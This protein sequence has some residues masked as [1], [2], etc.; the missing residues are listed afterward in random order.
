MNQEY[1][2]HAELATA[3]FMALMNLTDF[4]GQIR[5]TDLPPNENVTHH[6]GV[7]PRGDLME[8]YDKVQG[9]Y[10]VLHEA[11]GSSSSLCPMNAEAYIKG[12]INVAACLIQKDVDL[13]AHG[14]VCH[15]HGA[16]DTV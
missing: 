14:N 15:A 7:D 12:C 13:H 10:H 11:L 6:F 5:E 1:G 16:S 3:L 8:L 2:P 9:F 4:A